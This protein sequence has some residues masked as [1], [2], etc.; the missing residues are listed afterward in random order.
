[1]GA[2]VVPT[3]E[4]AACTFGTFGTPPQMVA[5]ET[6]Q[7]DEHLGHALATMAERVACVQDL[8]Q[9]HGEDDALVELPPIGPPILTNAL[10]LPGF[11]YVCLSDGQLVDAATLLRGERRGAPY[12]PL[13][14]A[15]ELQRAELHRTG[16]QLAQEAEEVERA[17]D[18]VQA[19]PRAWARWHE[20]EH[21]AVN[22]GFAHLERA[23]ALQKAAAGTRLVQ[24]RAAADER[25]ARAT[26]QLRGCRRALVRQR[27]ALRRFEARVGVPADGEGAADG[28]AWQG[29]MCV[30]WPGLASALDALGAPCEAWAEGEGASPQP[31][32]EAKATP[33]RAEPAADA[34]AA[35]PFALRARR[36]PAV[37]ASPAG[38]TPS[39][40]STPA[41]LPTPASPP[42]PSAFDS[43]AAVR[44]F[45][46][47]VGAGAAAGE[48]AAGEAAAGEAAAGEAAAGEAAAE[49]EQQAD[50]ARSYEIARCDLLVEQQAE[51]TRLHRQL[52]EQGKLLAAA[53]AQLA[54]PAAAARSAEEPAGEPGRLPQKSPDRFLRECLGQI[55]S[56]TAAASTAAAAA[57]A[58]VTPPPPASPPAAPAPAARAPTDSL[59]GGSSWLPVPAELISVRLAHP[60][61]NPK[62][63]PPPPPPP[64]RSASASDAASASP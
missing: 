30:A 2:V 18:A 59:S 63:Q 49:V 19:L 48:A 50:T 6:T 24:M 44:L 33:S 64:P 13:D 21:E 22:D 46:A 23:L 47:C 12:L 56:Y 53:Q 42:Q 57:A 54:A 31:C 14:E 26:E 28:D 52:A 7:L 35:A 11:E 4:F 16:R 25:A 29:R 62:P 27:Q 61:P 17:L 51:I 43:A 38:D 9:A 32:E 58:S 40:A 8:A 55:D 41:P 1:M 36:R 60:T 34:E 39:P 45:V 10:P 15:A 3:A 20:R 5:E 37:E